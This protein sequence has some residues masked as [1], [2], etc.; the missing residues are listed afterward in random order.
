MTQAPPKP[1][2]TTA[3]R[4][5]LALL[6]GQATP[7]LMIRSGTR[8]DTGRWWR[9]TRL[10]LCLTDDRLVLLA[11][12]RRAYGQSVPLTDCKDSQYNHLTGQLVIKPTEQLRF[13][14]V[15]LDPTEALAVLKHIQRH[16]PSEKTTTPTSLAT[17]QHLA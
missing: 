6:I 7:A 9:P 11:A 15:S 10:W 5:Q 1:K 8:I 3:E 13:P 14:H 17:E 12:S 16:E 4:Q 2:M